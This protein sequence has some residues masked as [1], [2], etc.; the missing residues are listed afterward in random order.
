MITSASG[1]ADRN[2][3][4]MQ[5]RTQRGFGHCADHKKEKKKKTGW[6]SF[7]HST[8]ETLVLREIYLSVKIKRKK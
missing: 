5:T 7:A 1:N 6:G 2:P 4:Q 3:E 8:S